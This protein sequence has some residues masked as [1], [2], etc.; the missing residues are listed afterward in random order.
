MFLYIN[1][2]CEKNIRGGGGGVGYHY[3]SIF[4]NSK[5]AFHN[6]KLAF[7]NWKLAFYNSKLAFHN[8]KL[9]FHNYSLFITRN[10]LFSTRNSLFTTRKRFSQLETR[11]LQ[12]ETRFLQLETRFSQLETVKKEL[13]IMTIFLMYCTYIS[14][15]PYVLSRHLYTH[16]FAQ[17]LIKMYQ[18]KDTSFLIVCFSETHLN[19][20]V[21]FLPLITCYK[22]VMYI[23]NSCLRVCF[24]SV[25]HSYAI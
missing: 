15:R 3:A 10:S 16:V 12:L 14:K 2:S 8:S 18:C 4:Y 22:K 5:L 11:F 21:K 19:T 1:L 6:W 23:C 25:S 20:C 13:I 7:Y 9:A 24:L 17:I